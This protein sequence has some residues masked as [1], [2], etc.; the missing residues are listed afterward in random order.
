MIPGETTEGS[1]F[2]MSLH[3]CKGLFKTMILTKMFEP[4]IVIKRLLI[5]KLKKKCRLKITFE[6]Q[7]SLSDHNAYLICPPISFLFINYS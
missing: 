6:G 2:E 1:N 7:T 4:G 5:K 3:H